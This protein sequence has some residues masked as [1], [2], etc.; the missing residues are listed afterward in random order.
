MERDKRYIEERC[1]RR[2]GERVGG[3]SDVRVSI[4]RFPKK[5]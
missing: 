3:T 1:V 2:D 5:L 4:L